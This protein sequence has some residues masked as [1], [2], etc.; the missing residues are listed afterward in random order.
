MD[1]GVGHGIVSYTGLVDETG[2][3]SD[4]IIFCLRTEGALVRYCTA[5]VHVYIYND[6]VR[7]LVIPVEMAGK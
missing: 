4:R 3:V 1:G 7:V 2:R 5:L 6:T